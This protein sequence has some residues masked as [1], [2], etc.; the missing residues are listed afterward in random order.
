MFSKLYLC[1]YVL[2][3]DSLFYQLISSGRMSVLY[4]LLT[5]RYALARE[6]PWAAIRAFA[7]VLLTSSSFSFSGRRGFENLV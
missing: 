5:W 7:T 1:T 4:M 2:V 6:G 3:C